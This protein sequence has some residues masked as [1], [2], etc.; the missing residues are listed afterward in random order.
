MAERP[1]Y[2]RCM[3][4]L[5]AL[6]LAV[7][8]AAAWGCGREERPLPAACTAGSNQIAHALRRAP[9]PVAL[10]DGTRLSVCL[11]R[12]RADAD[13]QTVGALYTQVATG[14]SAQV[15]ASD[16]AALRLGYLI[17]AAR[18]GTRHTGGIH[19]ELLR[20]LDQSVGLDGVPPRRSAAFRLGLAAGSRTG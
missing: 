4:R 13:I 20:R 5:A 8:T 2:D 3:V 1:L 15:P 11:E 14:L 6:M 19:L 12:A 10:G 16:T 18:R 9:A 7:T 17:G